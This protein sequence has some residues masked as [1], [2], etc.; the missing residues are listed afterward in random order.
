MNNLNKLRGGKKGPGPPFEDVLAAVEDFTSLDFWNLF[1]LACSYDFQT[2]YFHRILFASAVPC[3]SLLVGMVAYSLLKARPSIGDPARRSVGQ[4]MTDECVE[5]DWLL[6]EVM[7]RATMVMFFL[8]PTVR[9]IRQMV[10][11]YFPKIKF[12]V[13]L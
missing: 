6:L 9:G 8:F 11:L 1:N 7:K 3:L 10:N 13:K 2:S 12:G 4:A 5:R